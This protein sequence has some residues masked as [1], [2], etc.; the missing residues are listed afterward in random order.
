[1]GCIIMSPKS[2][3]SR[4]LFK[5]TVVG[6]ED[7]LLEELLSAFDDPVV[8]VDGIRIG[9]TEVD[10]DSSEVHAVFMSPRHSAMDILLAL[11]YRGASG[12]IIVLREADPELETVY[13][14]EIR[15]SLG[16]KIPTA[17]V[18][19]GSGLD[20]FKIQEIRHVVDEMIAEIFEMKAKAKKSK[21][22]PKKKSKAKK[23]SKKSSK[24]SKKSKT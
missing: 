21:P 7:K 16:T 5:I 1:M 2:E 12:V 9:S 15:D 20:N 6:P 17:V 8:A 14:N 11:T 19:I 23:S 22:A 10:F 4:Y 3:K 13:R 24:A 18:E